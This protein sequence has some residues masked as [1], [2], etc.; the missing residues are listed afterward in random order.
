MSKHKHIWPVENPHKKFLP[1]HLL[2]GRWFYLFHAMLALFLIYPYVE[3]ESPRDHPWVLT[4]LRSVVFMIMIVTVSFNPRQFILSLA[5]ALPSCF[6]YWIPVE[7]SWQFLLLGSQILFYIYV[8]L[9]VLPSILDASEIDSEDIFGALTLYLLAGL[10]WANLYQLIEIFLPGSYY[11][12][13]ENNPDGALTW[14][15]FLFF[16]FTTLTTLGYGD[17]TP[18]SSYARSLAILEAVSGVFFVATLIAR[19]IG[20]YVSENVV[21]QIKKG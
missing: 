8:F 11:V 9:L 16:S 7:A 17:I 4:T 5:L 1:T 12:A 14:S 20:Y 15:D 13:F 2:A 10:I 21:S 6:S 19:T 18:V 3:S